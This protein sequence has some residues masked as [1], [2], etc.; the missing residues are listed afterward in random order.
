MGLTFAFAWARPT[1]GVC[2]YYSTMLPSNNQI[3][4]L[5]NAADIT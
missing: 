1:R 4:H 5:C 2:E 3:I